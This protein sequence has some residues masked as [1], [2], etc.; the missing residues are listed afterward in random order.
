M[1]GPWK[2]L[3]SGYSK[4]GEVFTVPVVHKRVTFLIG[5]DVSPH[6]FKAGD[7]EMSQSEVCHYAGWHD[8]VSLCIWCCRLQVSKV[9]HHSWQGARPSTY[10]PHLQV[11]DF[12]V[13][14]FGPG[15]VYDVDQKVRTEQFRMF[16]EALTKNRLKAYIP[17]FN[18]E[19][20]VCTTSVYI[21][22]VGATSPI[23]IAFV[24]INMGLESHVC[25]YGLRSWPC[26][27]HRSA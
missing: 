13:P 14:T 11:Y 8:D 1:Q 17:Q 18:K 5:P 9:A 25:G 23:G 12:N 24:R 4:F 16:T 7:D 27:T 19:A 6:F 2:L 26:V 15:V 22:G 10:P 21:G 3:A 20:E